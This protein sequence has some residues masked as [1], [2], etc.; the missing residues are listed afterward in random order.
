ML[1]VLLAVGLVVACGAVTIDNTVL[2]FSPSPLHP[3]TFKA[4]SD[5]VRACACVFR[6]RGAISTATS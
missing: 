1:L 2:S 3:A 5:C 4:L 6:R